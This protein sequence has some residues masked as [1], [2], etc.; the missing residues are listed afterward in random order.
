MNDTS[1]K[2]HGATALLTAAILFMAAGASDALYSVLSGK[3][4]L[5]SAGAVLFCLG[6][7]LF[8]LSKRNSH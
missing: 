1:A 3:G 7:L 2:S 4:L 6:V 8:K 5:F